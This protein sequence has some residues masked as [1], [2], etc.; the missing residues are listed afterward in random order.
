MLICWANARVVIKATVLASIAKADFISSDE[1]VFDVGCPKK[2]RCAIA[3]R[4]L[5]CE[6]RGIQKIEG[7]LKVLF[8]Y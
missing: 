5:G 6:Y 2:F 3:K 4:R 8:L 1:K 7:E